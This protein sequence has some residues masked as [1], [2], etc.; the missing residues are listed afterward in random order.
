MS[1]TATSGANDSTDGTVARAACTA[2][3]YGFSGRSRVGKTWYS[4]AAANS[5]PAARAASSQRRHVCSATACPRATSAS[6][7]ASIGNACPG[8][9]NAPR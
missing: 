7:S 3:W 5:I 2:A 4:G 9:P 6:P 8:S 1:A